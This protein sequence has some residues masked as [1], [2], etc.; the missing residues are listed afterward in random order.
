MRNSSPI[1]CSASFTSESGRWSSATVSADGRPDELCDS[2]RASC[3]S[4]I[5]S[6]GLTCGS[7]CFLR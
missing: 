6:V 4:S 1:A 3:Q 7:R 2:A 5:S